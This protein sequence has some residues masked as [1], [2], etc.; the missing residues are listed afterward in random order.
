MRRRV[1]GSAFGTCARVEPVDFRWATGTDRVR[2]YESS[3][4]VRRLFCNRCGSTLAATV[5]GAVGYIA[6]GTVD[7]DPEV[8]P[9]SHVFVGSGA[10]RHDIGDILPGHEDWP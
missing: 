3:C 5:G 7:G 4:G 2:A 8:K 9:E 10:V 6:L 1:S